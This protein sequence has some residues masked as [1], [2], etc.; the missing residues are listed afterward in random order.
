ML[1]RGV[2]LYVCRA[3]PGGVRAGE[4]VRRTWGQ[5]QR[6]ADDEGVLRAVQEDR[7]PLQPSAQ[8]HH[9]RLRERILLPHPHQGQAA[10]RNHLGELQRGPYGDQLLNA[11]KYRTLINIFTIS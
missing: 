6:Q 9:Q 8:R 11:S 3:V 1:R 7:V 4:G 2:R 10:A 5:V